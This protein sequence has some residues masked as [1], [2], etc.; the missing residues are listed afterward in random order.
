MADIERLNCVTRLNLDP[1]MVL[2]AATGKL[3]E[4]LIIG[5]DKEDNYYFDSSI[6]GGPEALWLVEKFKQALMD[7]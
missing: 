2:E 6:A 7:V 5:L 3:E 4:V 1:D